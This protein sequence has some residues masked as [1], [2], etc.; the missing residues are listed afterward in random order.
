MK[1]SAGRDCD[2]ID[3]NLSLRC[4]LEVRRQPLSGVYFS[5]LPIRLHIDATRTACLTN[6]SWLK[7]ER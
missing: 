1:R 2:E 6:K 3:D 5:R 7:I 4:L